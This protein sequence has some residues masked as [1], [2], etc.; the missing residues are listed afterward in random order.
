MIQRILMKFQITL[1]ILHHL[2]YLKQHDSLMPDPQSHNIQENQD[3]NSSSRDSNRPYTE[4]QS[5]NINGYVNFTQ[6][7]NPVGT[8]DMKTD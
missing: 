5:D 6:K 8:S 4:N 1:A 7:R 3:Q 2:E